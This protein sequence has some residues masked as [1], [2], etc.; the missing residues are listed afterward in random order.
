MCSFYE[1]VREFFSVFSVIINAT[2]ASDN[3]EVGGY[4]E[5]RTDLKNFKS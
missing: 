1:R 2:D 3:E 4:S 5:F